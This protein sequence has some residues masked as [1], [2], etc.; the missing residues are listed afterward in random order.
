MRRREDGPWS[1]ADDRAVLTLLAVMCDL[2][3]R[4]AEDVV[5]RLLDLRDL[6][7]SRR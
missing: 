2:T 5:A 4:A 1:P 7:R 3:G 6:W